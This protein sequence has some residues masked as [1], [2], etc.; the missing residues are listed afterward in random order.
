M[1]SSLIIFSRYSQ[2]DPD[3]CRDVCG[4]YEGH[5]ASLCF[6]IVALYRNAARRHLIQSGLLGWKWKQL[7]IRFTG[8]RG[9]C[10]GAHPEPPIPPD[11]APALTRPLPPQVWRV[12][13]RCGSSC[14]SCCWTRNMST[15][16]AGPPTMVNSSSSKQKKWPSCGDSGK[17]KQTWTTTS[18][19]E[20]C[21]TIM[22]R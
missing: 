20:P 10:W 9:R 2:R 18:W 5:R 21:D 11:L 17:T 12:Q 13:S 4:E 16:S 8:G 3:T 6:W 1:G 14:C 22:T 7:S 15:W 19:A